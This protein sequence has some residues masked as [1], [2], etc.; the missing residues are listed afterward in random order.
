M[1]T[2]RVGKFRASHR[3]HTINPNQWANGVKRVKDYTTLKLK[4]NQAVKSYC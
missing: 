1:L 3:G 2:P 4:F